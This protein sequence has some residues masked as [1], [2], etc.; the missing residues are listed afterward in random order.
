MRYIVT[1]VCSL[2][3]FLTALAQ[4]Q[5]P[6][7]TG[8]IE[9]TADRTEIL[10]ARFLGVIDRSDDEGKVK[11]MKSFSKVA[12]YT[13]GTP[14]PLD[15]H[16]A[17][18]KELR[19][20]AVPEEAPINHSSRTVEPVVGTNFLGNTLVTGTPPDN[21]IAISNGGKIITVDN[22]SMAFH[23]DN[24]SAIMT[25]ELHED[26]LDDV[27]SSINI[28]SGLFDP[29]VVYDPV[30]DK[31][32]LVI[33]H[34]SSSST[35]KILVCYSQTNNPAGN[36]NVYEL[37]GDPLNN[38]S[39]LDYPQIGISENDLFITGNLFQSGS[40]SFN[41]AVVYQV[42]KNDGYAGVTNL[43]F[44]LYN[45]IPGGQIGAFSL[46]PAGFGQGGEYG[47][48]IY[49]VSSNSFSANRLNLYSV[50]GALNSNPSLNL[51]S[52]FIVPS[53][54]APADAIQSG[55]NAELSTNDSR[56]QHAFYLDGM[57][58]AVHQASYQNSG[59]SGIVYYRIPVTNPS[60]YE[61][62]RYG[63]VGVDYAFPSIASYG[64]TENDKSVM[65]G[66]LRVSGSTFP[67]IG[68]VNCDLSMDWSSPTIIK[69]GNSYVD[70][71][72]LS[73]TE[74]WG[75]YSDI[76]RKHN[77]TSPAVWMAG[78]FGSNSHNWNTWI[79]EIGGEYEPIPFPEALFEADTTVVYEGES[80]FF[81][82]SSLN[83]PTSWIWTF[84]G[85]DPLN[86]FNQHNLVQYD[87]T[88]WFDVTLRISNQYG[89][90][91]LVKESYIHV[92]STDTAPPV[93]PEGVS[94]IEQSMDMTVYP[95]PSTEFELVYVYIE[96][97][98]W[99]QVDINILDIQG[100]VVK[101]MYSDQM[102]PGVHRMTFNK[103]ALPSGQYIVQVRR[104]GQ[105]T[106][107][108]KIIVL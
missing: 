102:K 51:L 2:F 77:E 68:V 96:N 41:G 31:F 40:N 71:N 8:E 14:T 36:W 108:E 6:N 97:E 59:Y 62:A 27:A 67:E 23:N 89:G 35:S 19:N 58:Y 64:L 101:A 79:A 45:N 24:G 13:H 92:L 34:G 69:T 82:D 94:E 32:I 107:N 75:D 30:E 84:E 91:T 28:T 90:D 56:M 5:M 18:Q 87:D 55:T 25:N 80:V 12:A 66:F 83:Q 26:W 54:N 11:W 86:S 1:V 21:S 15:E 3:A 63:Q 100:R 17:Q 50:T 103:L 81:S 47:P 33:L 49:L 99:A 98:N 16:K 106:K 76:Q 48:G 88:G 20:N 57:V 73:G 61:T 29:R 74:R 72:W 105:I 95:N 44:T 93:E 4:H 39:W 53:Y 46:V 65:I 9:G 104:N 78:C 52:S 43:G 37:D 7:Y 85:G 42:E 38:G 22:S 60:A 70:H 10:Q